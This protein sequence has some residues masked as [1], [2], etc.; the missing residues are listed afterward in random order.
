MP[1]AKNSVKTIH[2]CHLQPTI[3]LQDENYDSE[4]MA[5]AATASLAMP[6]R[7]NYA[8]DATSNI[9]SSIIVPP[10]QDKEVGEM[11]A[12]GGG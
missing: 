12:A 7:E 3:T 8:K 11:R 2:N 6:P 1:N 9:D 10:S 4:V 5:P